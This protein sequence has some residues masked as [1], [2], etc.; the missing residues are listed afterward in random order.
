MFRM[1]RVM[2]WVFLVFLLR[3]VSMHLRPFTGSIPPPG[4][5]SF[6]VVMEET[7]ASGRVHWLLYDIP[8][9]TRFLQELIDSVCRQGPAQGTLL[10]KFW[11]YG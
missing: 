1:K 2:G 6:V 8:G 10:F 3:I 5:K 4:T 7:G 9:D 11:I